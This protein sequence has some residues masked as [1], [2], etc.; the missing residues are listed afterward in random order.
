M[1]INLISLKNEDIIIDEDFTFSKE[2]LNK[3]GILDLKNTHASGIIKK[4]SLNNLLIDLNITGKM[5]LPCSRTLEPVDY[6]F[7]IKI[8]GDLKE[9]YDEMCQKEEN[10]E[11]SI[12][13]LP[14]IWENIL[15][16]I[17]MRIVS[18]NAKE[19]PTEGNGWRLVTSDKGNVNPE[20]AKL[21]DLL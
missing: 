2:E 5:V 9:I 10:F 14:I 20:L 15:M 7:D 16:E 8:D 13:I 19:I 3:A 11:N 6:P 12:D 18:K 1:N 21:Q 17:P 4:D